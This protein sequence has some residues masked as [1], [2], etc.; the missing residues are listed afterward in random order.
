MGLD[1][2][3]YLALDP[4]VRF[5]PYREV[6]DQDVVVVLRF[7]EEEA[8]AWMRPGDVPRLHAPSP[9]APQ[10]DQDARGWRASGG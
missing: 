3:A 5:A 8:L 9:D 10:P 1:A 7:P 6:F 4:R 2:E